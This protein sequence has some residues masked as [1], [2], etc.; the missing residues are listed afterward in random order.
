MAKSFR[1][2]LEIEYKAKKDNALFVFVPQVIVEYGNDANV[3]KDI[4]DLLID[5]FKNNFIVLEDDI[6]PN[7]VKQLIWNFDYFIGT[8][9]HSNIF[10][11]SMGKPTIA[12]AY[13][14]K[15]NGI[16]HT[17]EMDDYVIEMKSISAK[18]LIELSE[19]Q[20]NN[21]IVIEKHLNNKIKNIRKE[22]MK[23]ITKVMEEL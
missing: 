3:A 16:M 7:E 12:I 23:K 5:K 8:R 20:K 18:K 11:I 22:I 6:H 1:Q 4:K 17:V 10:A 19:K 13:E 15:T 14:K 2:P 21:K 9:M